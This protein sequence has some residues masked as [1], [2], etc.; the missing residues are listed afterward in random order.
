M[1]DEKLKSKIR[2]LSRAV[3]KGEERVPVSYS[4]GEYTPE[5]GLPKGTITIYAKDY[6]ALP[7][8][9]NPQ[10]DSDS[11]TDYF[12][13]DRARVKPGSKYYDEV[14][15]ALRKREA[16]EKN[17][18]ARKNQNLKDDVLKN[19][20]KKFAKLHEENTLLDYELSGYMGDSERRK[21]FR[22][23][24]TH[25]VKPQKKYAY[26]DQLIN[27]INSGGS[28]RFMVQTQGADKGMVFSIKGYGQRGYPLGDI[29]KQIRN[30]EEGNK[31]L[32]EEVKRRS[33][34]N[35]K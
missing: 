27:G 9:L 28:G 14:M 5:S 32:F 10:N 11:M 15:M 2:F 18:I 19:K 3:V 21:I 26:V 7:E 20:I 16:Q 22:E 35:R 23:S 8:E 31:N 34:K 25:V 24:A 17:A 6:K 33:M 29:D 30:L 4:K 13:N 12:E 1:A